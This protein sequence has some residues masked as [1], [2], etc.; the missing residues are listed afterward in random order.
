MAVTIPGFKNL[1]SKPLWDIARYPQDLSNA[2]ETSLAYSLGLLA[3]RT[4]W[5]RYKLSSLELVT[6]PGGAQGFN[7]ALAA[8]TDASARAEVAAARSEVIADRLGGMVATV[9]TPE[10]VELVKLD[11]ATFTSGMEPV[12]INGTTYTISYVE[13]EQGGLAPQRVVKSDALNTALG[14]A[15]AARQD[16]DAAIDLVTRDRVALSALANSV[17]YASYTLFPPPA[18]LTGKG[19][20]AL[21]TGAV[22]Y[23]DGATWGPILGYAILRPE[24]DG[25]RAR[26]YA[27]EQG[28]AG[29]LIGYATLAA[30]QANLNHPAGTVGLVTNDSASANNGEYLKLGASGAGSWQKAS[31]SRVSALETRLNITESIAAELGSIAPTAVLLGQT[32]TVSGTGQSNYQGYGTPVGSRTGVRR[33]VVRLKLQA[34]ATKLLAHVRTGSAGAIT[35]TLSAVAIPGVNVT[36]DV[37]FESPVPL[38][39]DHLDVV[40]D[41]NLQ[42]RRT[43]T[44]GTYGDAWRIRTGGT[45]EAPTWIASTGGSIW[46]ALFYSL[47][48]TNKVLTLSA[49]MRAGVRADLA[50]ELSAAMRSDN[51]QALSFLRGYNFTTT[52]Q[53]V[54]DIDSA[55]GLNNAGANVSYYGGGS[56]IGALQNF[57]FL[58]LSISG[59]RPLDAPISLGRFVFY[60][61]ST[62]GTVLADVTI[63]IF[64]PTGPRAKERFK[65]PIYLPS[66]IVN[67][68]GNQIFL[69]AIFNGGVALQVAPAVMAG[70][71][72][73]SRIVVGGTLAAPAQAIS[74]SVATGFTLSVR[75]GTYDSTKLRAAITPALADSLRIDPVVVCT[76]VLPAVVGQE[77]NL[78]FSNVLL[79]PRPWNTYSIDVTT[80]A[81][82][83]V[84]RQFA[85]AFRW[86]PDTAGDFPIKLDVYE[87]DFMVAS[88]SG[89]IRVAAANA[90]AGVVRKKVDMGDS[91]TAQG[92]SL[93]EFQRLSQADASGYRV[94][95]VGGRTITIKDSLGVD[96][97][98]NHEGVSGVNL[99]WQ[100]THASSH[101]TTNGVFNFAQFNAT[102]NTGLAAGD[103]LGVRLGTNDLFA[104]TRDNLTGT[105]VARLLESRMAILENIISTAQAAVPGLIVELYTVIPP[106]F[107]QDAF[108]LAGNG[109]G[110]YRDR[111]HRSVLLWNQRLISQFSGRTAQNVHVLPIHHAIDPVN[112]YRWSTDTI[113]PQT[114]A[115]RI[116][117][118][119][120]RVYDALHPDLGGNH[121]LADAIFAF[122]KNLG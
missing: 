83:G 52:Y 107:T 73:P 110:M 113:Q 76:P 122:E 102:Y 8:L 66:T 90:G 101:F 69:M 17:P 42:Q 27:V 53:T 3:D 1:I 68:A 16:V 10:Y 64:P 88:W 99:I 39:F 7:D 36:T 117:T 54:S 13:I 98:V 4:E 74:S 91:N 18:T 118:R 80:T 30:L 120:Y 33:I 14:A 106:A 56:Q 93:A 5:L 9:V 114:A 71:T 70:T 108:A 82:N 44:S 51:Y 57:N 32:D 28:Q 15:H 75:V 115:A 43:A 67:A 84:G 89:T 116:P 50:P 48:D 25:I 47:D 103:R 78:Y 46:Y 55:A 12:T 100:T 72:V 45:P 59:D 92:V 38:S 31:T 111:F 35:A 86:T 112:G 81:N 2:D 109:T 37:V 79:A 49:K 63:P 105:S 20:I 96:Q 60:D 24:L 40:A 94:N 97:I 104:S 85:D 26:L 22:Y 77:F 6:F 29:G 58:E 62:A 119:V 121:Q 34:A 95:L 23:S 21:D 87:G 19:A 61:S 11:G 41:A 65:I